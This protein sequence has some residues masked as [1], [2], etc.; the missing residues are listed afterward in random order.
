MPFDVFTN[1]GRNLSHRGQIFANQAIDAAREA[2]F[3][4]DRKT[5]LV[6]LANTDATPEKFQFKEI[7][8]FS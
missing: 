5:V 4:L 3:I 1:I 2:A 7:P 6:K 8:T